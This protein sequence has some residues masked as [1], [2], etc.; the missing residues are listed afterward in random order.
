MSKH[1]SDEE[2]LARRKLLRIMGLSAAMS[3]MPLSTLL[4][5]ELALPDVST[6]KVTTKAAPKPARKPQTSSRILMIDAGHG[7]KD[8]GA[9]GTRG[10]Q[11]KDVVLEIARELADNLSGVRGINVK[12]T[13][14][15]DEFI[16]LKE[17]VM[18]AQSMKADLFISIHADSAP[19]ANARGL[20]AYTL[21]NK[22]SDG[23]AAAI[24]KQENIAD[25]V[26]GVPYNDND[27]VNAILMDLAA[28]HTKNASLTVKTNLVKTVG[29]EWG[30]LENPMRSANFAVLK[31]PEVPSVLLE[32]GFLSNKKDEEILSSRKNR[33][34]IANLL[35]RE[36]ATIL[37]NAPSV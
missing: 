6:Y 37:N 2:L 18:M 36:L 10:T 20:S 14:D 17:R 21:S 26:G 5:K 1:L 15:N 31:A 33:Q 16:P 7:G 19:D 35:S 11:E 25:M 30:L 27:D 29:R 24:A 23:F 28:R 8:P 12:L 13:R 9:I 4:A 22:A 3:F 34:K 32:T